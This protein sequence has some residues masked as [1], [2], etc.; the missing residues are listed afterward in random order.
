MRGDTRLRDF[1]P[2]IVEIGVLLIGASMLS[3]PGRTFAATQGDSELF[4]AGKVRAAFLSQ[5]AGARPA[6][7]GE[8]FTAVSNDASAVSWNPGG[9]GQLTSPSAVM[10]YDVM[11]DDIGMAYLAGAMK[12]G[13]GVFGLGLTAVTYGELVQRD[14]AG[15][16]V[17]TES[18]LDIA[19]AGA[20]TMENPWGPKGWS[21][22]ALE[23]VYENAGGPLFCASLGTILR[24]VGKW[25]V[26]VAALHLGPA[27][28]GFSPPATM[29]GGL[30]Y[31][32]TEGLDVA[33]DASYGIMDRSMAGTLGIEYSPL[34]AMVL[35]IGYKRDLTDQGLKGLTGLAAGLGFRWRSFGLDYAFQP[36]GDLATS[37][38]IG[39]VYGRNASPQ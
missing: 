25:S 12:L 32:V 37:H 31:D 4:D 17:G 5:A 10:V 29:K 30:L 18:P 34:H 22:I 19:V 11:G 36:F 38:R 26:G 27:V 20:Y 16:K 7:M 6:G 9:L 21:G 1:A 24:V 39:L 15:A 28:K 14:D 23:V 2:M 33:L 3:L 8:A 13:S 35:R